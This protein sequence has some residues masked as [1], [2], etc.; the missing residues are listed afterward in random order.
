MA[1]VSPLLRQK[2][3]SRPSG[4]QLGEESTAGSLVR[5]RISELP[6]IF[7]QMSQLSDFSPFHENATWFP[8]GDKVGVVSP[9]GIEVS[10]TTCGAEG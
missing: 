2:A 1:R 6:I 8:S 4:D 9:P 10:D 7:S 3:I 5:R